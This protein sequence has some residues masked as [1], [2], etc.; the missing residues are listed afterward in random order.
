MLSQL[1]SRPHKESSQHKIDGKTD[2]D[3]GTGSRKGAI[4]W[5]LPLPANSHS[6]Q[7]KSAFPLHSLLP[8]STPIPY[9]FPLNILVDPQ[10][11]SGTHGKALAFPWVHL[12]LSACQKTAFYG[13]CKVVNTGLGSSHVNNSNIFPYLLYNHCSGGLEEKNTGNHDLAIDAV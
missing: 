8:H 4:I 7:N 12:H 9:H 3:H 10:W 5:W 13:C 6:S 11:C 2:P 1:M